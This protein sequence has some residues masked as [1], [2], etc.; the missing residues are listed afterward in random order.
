V[1]KVFRNPPEYILFQT[2]GDPKGLPAFF[3]RGG[4]C[5]QVPRSAALFVI[6]NEGLP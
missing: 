3:Y 5:L 2:A 6:L 4:T 1:V